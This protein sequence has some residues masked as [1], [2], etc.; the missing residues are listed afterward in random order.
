MNIIDLATLGEKSVINLCDGKDL[1]FVC[2]IRFTRDEG[3]ICSL[4]IPK[5]GGLFSFGKCENIIIPW[6]KVECIGEDAILVRINISEC[7]CECEGKGKGK[8]RAFFG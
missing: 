3:R 5:D 4:V 1:G 6:D 2:D 7:K 8:K